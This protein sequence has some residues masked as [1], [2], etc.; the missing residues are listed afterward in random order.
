MADRY[1]QGLLDTY[2]VV[3]LDV[4]PD[5]DLPVY[6]AI[7]AVTLAELSQG[8]YLAREASARVSRIEPLQA[9]DAAFG[10]L[11]RSTDAA[12]E[13]TDRSSPKWS[14]RVGSR[15]HAAST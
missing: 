15:N 13:S 11:C 4:I 9:V 8:P 6:G 5:S 14:L 10:H 3:D 2:V 7:S 1:A 12:P